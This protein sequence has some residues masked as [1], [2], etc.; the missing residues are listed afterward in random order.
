MTHL[1]MRWRTASAAIAL[2]ASL[3]VTAV[4]R[5]Q[6][7]GNPKGTVTPPPPRNL[8]AEGGGGAAAQTGGHERRRWREARRQRGADAGTHAKR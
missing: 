7:T 2:L 6:P 8:G 4:A 1:F 3:A 5:A